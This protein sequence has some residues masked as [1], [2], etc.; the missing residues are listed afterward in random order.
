MIQVRWSE[1]E[2]RKYLEREALLK[3][4][5]SRLVYEKGPRRGA[6][7]ATRTKRGER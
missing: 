4:A 1:A 6:E 2:Y 5:A 7:V 3:E